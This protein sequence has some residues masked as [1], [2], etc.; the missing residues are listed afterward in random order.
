MRANLNAGLRAGA[1]G[2][3]SGGTRRLTQ[4]LIAAEIALSLMLI[5]GAGLLL[6]SVLKF[7]A[8][9][10]GFDYNHVVFSYINLPERQ[11]P[12]SADKLRLYEDLRTHLGSIPGVEAS[13]ISVGIAAFGF[14]GY[15]VDIEGRARNEMHDVG[16]NSVSPDYFGVLRIALRRGR[17]LTRQDGAG[18][19]DVAVVNE[20]FASQYFPGVDPIGKHLR[21]ASQPGSSLEIVGVVGTEK[22][23]DF[24]HEMSWRE[25]PIV[26]RP[27]AQR[28]FSF[29]FIEVRTHGDQA[30]AGQA[31]ERTIGGIDKEI[32]VG[33]LFTRKD[34]LGRR[35]TYPRFR[36]IV[37]TQFSGLA[38]LLAALGL[39]G[40]L[41]QY[42]TQRRRELGLRMAIGARRQDIA[43][44]VAIQGGM[45]LLTG[46]AIGM[47]LTFALAGYLANLLFGVSASDPF[48]VIAAPVALLAVAL[49]A[50]AKPALDAA[51]V[52][53]IQ[54]LRDE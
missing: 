42:V 54:A 52:D 23:P 33:W 50:G 37:L 9:P 28:P 53:P 6:R 10:L 51:S 22:Q 11:Y 34:A 13:A 29:M 5:S 8:A 15:E 4:V 19:A 2:A 44:L 7:D 48:T 40:L 49:V 24:V 14:G 36:A 30:G 12:G 41:S 26:Y 16:E 21:L 45:P 38:L 1:R 27:I 46:I 35:F 31:I 47:V 17:L 43:R 18:S 20:K 25:Q 39:H 32:P 3:T